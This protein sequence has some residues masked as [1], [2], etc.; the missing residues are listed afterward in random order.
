MFKRGDIVEI[1]EQFQDPGD[2]T[3]TWI[4]LHEEEKGRVDITP[5]DIKLNIKPTYTL[6]TSQIKLVIANC[7]TDKTQ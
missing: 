3:F 7:P 2:D 4:V 5:V 1:L 6:K